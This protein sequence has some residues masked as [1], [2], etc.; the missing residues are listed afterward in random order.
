MSKTY[1]KKIHDALKENKIKSLSILLEQDEEETKDTDSSKENE[2]NK[3]KDV[4]FGSALDGDASKSNK[5]S[6]EEEEDDISN[7]EISDELDDASDTKLEDTLDDETLKTSIAQAETLLKN[8]AQNQ[9]T[10]FASIEKAADA[11]IQNAAINASANENFSVLKRYYNTKSIGAFINEADD[12]KVK[13]LANTMSGLDDQLRK[14]QD[15]V[16][17]I[18][19]GIDIHMPTFVKEAIESL[20][21]FD[22]KFSKENIIFSIFRNK[23]AASSGKKAKE[24]IEEFERLF[25]KELNKIDDSVSPEDV[26]IPLEKSHTAQGAMKQ[27]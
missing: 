27:G 15:T 10:P 13:K 6:S 7:E 24:N 4:M 21:S 20:L 9:D 3:D 19:K 12:Q 2:D 18:T 14:Y 26:M 5:K 17:S 16:D 8:I 1:G 22:S 25:Y 23:L 11:A